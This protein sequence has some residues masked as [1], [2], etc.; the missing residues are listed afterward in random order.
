MAEC[1]E[2][3]GEKF[4]LQSTGRYYQSGDKTKAERLLHRRIWIEHFGE[5]PLGYAVH[6]IDGNWRNNDLSNLEIMP[7]AEHMRRHM[8]DRW[9]D[10]RYSQKMR[11]N[12]A[13]AIEAA[14]EWHSSPEG[15]EWHKRNGKAAWIG[16]K[17]VA[18]SVLCQVCSAEIVTFF[19]TRTRFCSRNCDR[20]NSYRVNFTS[21]RQCACCGAKFMANKYRKTAYCSRAC[22]NRHRVGKT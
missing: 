21:E 1:L 2:Y 15:I 3:K 9:Q 16:R 12:L 7:A 11:N 20:A 22:S 6:H 8:H 14:K 10:P 18:S 13:K 5:I 17:R 19:P 4:W